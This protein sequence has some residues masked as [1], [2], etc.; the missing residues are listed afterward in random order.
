[1]NIGTFDSG[2]GGLLIT[3]SLIEAMPEYNFCYL[4]DTLHVPYGARSKEVVYTFTKNCIEYLFEKKDCKL[5]I[6]ACNTATFAALRKLQ[7]T[8]LPQKYPVLRLYAKSI[9]NNRE[10]E[11]CFAKLPFPMAKYHKHDKS[12]FHKNF[13]NIYD[14]LAYPLLICRKQNILYRQNALCQPKVPKFQVFLSKSKR[15]S[16]KYLI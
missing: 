4:G 2:L 6:I 11:V 10:N 5:I 12:L 14:F 8:Y 3:K 7:Q 16:S 15:F 1:M 13:L 9:Q